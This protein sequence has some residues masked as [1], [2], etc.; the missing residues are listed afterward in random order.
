[1][2]KPIRSSMLS[3]RNVCERITRRLDQILPEMTLL[4]A[5]SLNRYQLYG[6][7]PQ[8]ITLE[9]EELLGL[10]RFI[11]TR[12]TDYDECIYMRLNRNKPY[13]A[14]RDQRILE[15]K[16]LSKRKHFHWISKLEACAREKLAKGV[17]QSVQFDYRGLLDD[18]QVAKLEA[19]Q[20]VSEEQADL[21]EPDFDIP[22]FG[23]QPAQA[24]SLEHHSV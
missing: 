6:A 11:G 13:V 16:P 2:T 17:V 19:P 7:A 18:L 14:P 22:E 15:E 5:P 4:Y 1:M 20:A 23:P 12:R 10:W 9:L 3:I 24:E 8:P 21:P